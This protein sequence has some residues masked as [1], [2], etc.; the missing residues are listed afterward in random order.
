MPL[1]TRHFWHEHFCNFISVNYSYLTVICNLRL[2]A[3]F[4]QKLCIITLSVHIVTVIF[5]LKCIKEPQ[6]TE[7]FIIGL[8]VWLCASGCGINRISLSTAFHFQ[9]VLNV[10]RFVLDV[11]VPLFFQ[12]GNC[13]SANIQLFQNNYLAQVISPRLLLLFVL[14]IFFCFSL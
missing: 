1:S 11:A 5:C 9:P 2:F 10:L 8:W 3:I 13:L 6:I 4:T 7:Q 12:W 14:F